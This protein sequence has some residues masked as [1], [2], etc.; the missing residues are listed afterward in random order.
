MRR[1]GVMVAV[2]KQLLFSAIFFHSSLGRLHWPLVVFSLVNQISGPEMITRKTNAKELRLT[3]DLAPS[4]Q[5]ISLTGS[6]LPFAPLS[7]P[8]HS[9]APL[10]LP[11]VLNRCSSR[12]AVLNHISFHTLPFLWVTLFMSMISTSIHTLLMS[13]S[14]PLAHITCW[15]ARSVLPT[16]CLIGMSIWAATNYLNRSRNKCIICLVPL[17]PLVFFHNFSK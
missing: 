17:P 4:H 7:R 10:F 13:K 12:D 15:R 8:L 16:N 9:Q 3:H 2:L 14:L 11:S 1:E 6:R 5:F